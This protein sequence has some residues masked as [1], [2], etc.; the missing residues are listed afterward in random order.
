MKINKCFLQTDY[1]NM[2]YRTPSGLPRG[3]TVSSGGCGMVSVLNIMYNY[4]GKTGITITQMRDLAVSSGARYNGGTDI[5]TLLNACKSKWGG[6][7]FEYT[8][9]DSAMKAHVSKGGC[10]VMHTSGSTPLFSRSGHFVAACGISGSK[11]QVM[12]SF[13]YAG[14]WTEN[15][16]RKAHIKTTSIKGVVCADYTTVAAACDYYYL[17]TKTT[18]KVAT[19]DNVTARTAAGKSNDAIGSI[20]KGVT[21]EL[22]SATENWV[23]ISVWIAKKY[24][25]TKNGTATIKESVNFRASNGSGSEKLGVG[26]KGATFSIL[27]ETDNWI[28]TS[29]WI[30][31]KYTK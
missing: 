21:L 31:K 23:Q 4:V 28:K 11:I 6:F 13:Y 8:T 14:K 24:C 2:S 16:T 22:L 17:V 18:P 27:D 25:S 5:K 15:S 12:D 7:I 1:P 30:A 29:V 19:I 9:S 10:A 20:D 26:I 3:A